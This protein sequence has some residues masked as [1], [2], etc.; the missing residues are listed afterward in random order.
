[1]F[2]KK[3]LIHQNYL[4]DAITPAQTLNQKNYQV[5]KIIKTLNELKS[6]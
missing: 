3:E 1:M 6:Y 5:I 2:P 4:S